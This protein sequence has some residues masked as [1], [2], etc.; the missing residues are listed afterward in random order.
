MDYKSLIY[1]TGTVPYGTVCYRTVPVYGFYGLCA[2]IE[3]CNS[4]LGK[5]T[6]EERVRGQNDRALEH[7]QQ[8]YV[9]RL[10]DGSFPM[11]HGTN[12]LFKFE[13]IVTMTRVRLADNNLY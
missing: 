9:Y 1:G 8:L 12:N 6:V 5:E 13:Y 4:Q 11:R 2:T 7:C 3:V 10:E